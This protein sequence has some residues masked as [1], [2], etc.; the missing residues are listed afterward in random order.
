M[1]MYK[2]KRIF[3]HLVCIYVSWHVIESVKLKIYRACSGTMLKEVVLLL[4]NCC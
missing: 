4:R 2:N 3:K 1:V